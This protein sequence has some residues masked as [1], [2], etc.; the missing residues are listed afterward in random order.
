MWETF[1]A[2]EESFD[3][4]FFFLWIKGMKIYRRE[5]NEKRFETNKIMS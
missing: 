3:V 5:R 1:D 2:A 4:D